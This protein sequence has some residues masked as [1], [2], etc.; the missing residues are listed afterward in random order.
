[1][2][3]LELEEGDKLIAH[4]EKERL[5]LEKQDKI[6]QRLKNRFTEVSKDRS[7]ANELIAEGRKAAKE[8]ADK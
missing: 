8:G 2:K 4:D 7:L 5:V 1:M 6:K 3:L